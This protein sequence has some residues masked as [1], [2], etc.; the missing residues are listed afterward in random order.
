[1]EERM[2]G[3]EALPPLDDSPHLADIGYYKQRPILFFQVLIVYALILLKYG[4]LYFPGL[5]LRGFQMKLFGS[6]LLSQCI[7]VHQKTSYALIYQDFDVKALLDALIVLLLFVVTIMHMTRLSHLIPNS[8]RGQ[9]QVMAQ[10]V[11]EKNEEE[12]QLTN[13]NSD[14]VYENHFVSAQESELS[15]LLQ[16]SDETGITDY[17][18]TALDVAI[19][20]A[21]AGVLTLNFLTKEGF[22]ETFSADSTI[23]LTLKQYGLTKTISLIAFYSLSHLN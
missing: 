3:E 17:F 13:A 18:F 10:R 14:L 9:Y 7:L 22:I 5:K 11:M 21:V 23:Y 6:L 16:F 1:M 20:V 19:Q 8:W 4:P 15:D 2:E 12:L